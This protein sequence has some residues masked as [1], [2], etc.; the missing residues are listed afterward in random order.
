MLRRCPG[1]S[2][3]KMAGGLWA[4]G[5][6]LPHHPALKGRPIVANHQRFFTRFLTRIRTAAS[7]FETGG[8]FCTVK[9][10]RI[11]LVRRNF[12]LPRHQ[13][14]LGGDTSGLS[15]HGNFSSGRKHFDPS[16]S[17]FKPDPKRRELEPDKSIRSPQPRGGWQTPFILRPKHCGMPPGIV[18]CGGI[19]L[20]CRPVILS[21]QKSLASWQN[22]LVFLRRAGR[23]ASPA[24]RRHAQLKAI[25][26]KQFFYEIMQRG[27]KILMTLLTWH[28]GCF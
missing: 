17:I 3:G 18:G 6:R 19:I 27:R 23:P 21:R 25:P 7:F 24:R 5:C 4:L 10:R 15:C 11:S 26:W 20:I 1:R 8:Q 22:A 13:G 28:K 12:I 16:P 2:M 9:S 14:I